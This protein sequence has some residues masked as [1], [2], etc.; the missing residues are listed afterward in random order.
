MRLD[1]GHGF[2]RKQEEATYAAGMSWVPS[3]GIV[4]Q[5]VHEPVTERARASTHR[6][7]G[8]VERRNYRPGRPGADDMDA[9][10]SHRRRSDRTSPDPLEHRPSAAE[11]IPHGHPDGIDARVH[12]FDRPWRYSLA[13]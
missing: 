10:A 13:S 11:R 4:D 7:D 12:D 2:R 9:H 6:R 8:H 3:V 5:R 1:A